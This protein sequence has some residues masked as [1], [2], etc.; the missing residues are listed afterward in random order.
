MKRFNLKDMIG[1]WII[2][3]F[4]PSL[5]KTNEVEVAV[6]RYKAGDYDS[7]H[8][9]KIGTEFTVVVSG[10]IE[11]SGIIFVED[12]I[13]VIPPLDSTDFRALT[14]AVT[15]V[16]KIPGANLDKYLATIK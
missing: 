14:D 4:D 9:H 16:V 13:L 10:M 3:N 7:Q 2:G 11:M 8:Y 5:F 1:G 6:K 12:D 15:V